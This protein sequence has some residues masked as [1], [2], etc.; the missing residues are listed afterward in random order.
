MGAMSTVAVSLFW[1]PAAFQGRLGALM[2]EQ[3]KNLPGRDPAAM[4]QVM[5]S[6]SGTDMAFAMLFGMIGFFVLI[7][8]LSMAGG[9]LGAKFV[10][11]S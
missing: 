7:T 6:L 4:Q 11:R 3:L 9:A 1:L 8:G 10:R 5:R 2:Q